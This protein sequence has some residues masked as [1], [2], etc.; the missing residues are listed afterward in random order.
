[1]SKITIKTLD[2]IAH[3]NE[4]FACITAYDASFAK[5]IARAEIETLL[6]GDS[7]GNVIQGESTTVPVTLEEMA[8]HLGCV[9]NGLHG[10]QHQ[11]FLI[12]DMPFMSYATTELAL[13]SATVLMQAGAQM[14]KIE[15]A[16]WLLDSVRFLSERGLNVCG[17]LGLTPQTVD[18]LGGFRVQGRNPDQAEHIFK[19]A[20]ALQEAGARILVLECVPSQLAKQITEALDIPVIGIGAGP[21]TNSQVL[22]LYDLLGISVGNRPRFVKDFLTGNDHGIS[23][24]LRAFRDAVISGDFPQQEHCFE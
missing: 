22:V 1:M 8:Y 24:A 5:L 10:E 17:H 20:N 14:V 16:E 18:S 13:E 21:F 19:Q 3:Q 2:D 11:P 9:S 6:V 12:A 4:K 7:L 23:G 15:G